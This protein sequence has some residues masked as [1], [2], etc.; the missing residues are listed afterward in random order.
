MTVPE[1]STYAV[2]E[3]QQREPMGFLPLSIHLPTPSV[4]DWGLL[5]GI[6]RI[7][8]AA[9]SA[10]WSRSFQDAFREIGRLAGAPEATPRRETDTVSVFVALEYAGKKLLKSIL[11]SEHNLSD[12]PLGALV[13]CSLL[14]DMEP[15]P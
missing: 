2:S 12:L 1:L 9:N 8:Q 10:R 13:L 15:L 4:P 3:Y 14:E 6:S 11:D 5:Q 7:H